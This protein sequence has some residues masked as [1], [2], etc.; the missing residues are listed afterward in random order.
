MET[1]LTFNKGP[2]AD[3]PEYSPDG[4]FIYYNSSKSGTMQIWRMKPDGTDH[5]QITFDEHNDWFPHISPDNKW[6]VKSHEQFQ[7]KPSINIS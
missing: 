1:Q 2:L 7:N 5:E 3:G 4:K 6:I